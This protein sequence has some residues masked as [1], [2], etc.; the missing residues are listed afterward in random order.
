MAA[1][2]L[3]TLLLVAAAGIAGFAADPS[4][5]QTPELPA[6]DGLL[7]G[8]GWQ[9]DQ[10]SGL[11]QQRMAY[12]QWSLSDPSGAQA[13]LFIGAT[14]RPQTLFGWSG[15][16]G[17]L[18]EGYLVESSSVSSVRVGAAAGSITHVRIRRGSDLEEVAYS[19]VRP[20]G[21]VASGSDAVLGLS[22]DA[23]AH[24][25]SP[26][27][28]VRVVI[29]SSSRGDASAKTAASLLTAVLTAIVRMRSE[30]R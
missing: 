23:L 7:S 1:R 8:S 21:I 22:W 11:V 19:A 5:S 15:E 28:A 27:Y 9:V 6:V 10:A 17:Y 14:S 25:G 2:V 18:G 20:D 13:L 4:A 26:Y 12:Q 30:T 16:L 3:I 29:P 24:R